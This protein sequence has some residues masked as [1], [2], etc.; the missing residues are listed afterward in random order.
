M[1]FIN[2]SSCE[3]HKFAI[4]WSELIEYTQMKHHVIFITDYFVLRFKEDI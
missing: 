1:F 3:H 2:L 4:V